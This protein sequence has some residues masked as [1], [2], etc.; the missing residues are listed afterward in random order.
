MLAAV[1]LAWPTGVCS[2]TSGRRA[3]VIL[4]D[5]FTWKDSRDLGG[6]ELAGLLSAASV[7][8]SNA[9]TAD[10]GQSLLAACATL[11]A[12]RRMSARESAGLGLGLYELSGGEAAVDIYLRRMGPL[13]SS[14]AATLP[15]A[16]AVCTAW[17]ELAV[18]NA[19]SAYRGKPGLLGE[20]LCRAGM[21]AAAIGTSDDR[22]QASR[23]A[24]LV[25]MDARGVVPWAQVGP[26]VNARDPHAPF[27]MACDIR[28]MAAAAAGAAATAAGARIGLVMI[29][30][31]DFARL[32]RYEVNLS[33]ESYNLLLAQCYGRLDSLL[34]EMRRA[35]GPPS[36]ELAYVLV[37]P[38]AASGLAPIAIAGWSYGVGL[39]TSPTTRREGLV[40]NLD[41]TPTILAGLGVGPAWD[42]D[43]APMVCAP[44]TAVSPGAGIG[45][46]LGAPTDYVLRA[47]ITEEAL[48]KS[49]E[50]R[51]PVLRVLIGLLVATVFGL[52]G[53][54][55][56]GRRASRWAV[57]LVRALL[58]AASAAPL[59]I[60]LGPV[61]GVCGTAASISLLV[62]GCG[63]LAFLALRA[64]GSSMWS[65]VLIS[66]ATAIVIA[67]DALTGGRL[68]ST[69][70]L[71]HSAVL[72]ARYYGVGNELM[73]LLVG[74]AALVG[75][76]L[77]RSAWP[78]AA[79]SGLAMVMLGHPSIGANFGGMISAAFTSLAIAVVAVA[80]PSPNCPSRR[81]YRL[82]LVVLAGLIVATLSAATALVLLDASN[83]GPSHIGRAW[84]AL[85]Q[86][87][88]G[89][90]QLAAIIMRKL[91]MNIRLLRYTAWTQVL[92]A[93]LII[94]GAMAASARGVFLQFRQDH[95]SLH[96]AFMGGLAGALAAMAVNDSGVVACA[97]LAMMPTLAM[98]GY[99]ADKLAA[100]DARQGA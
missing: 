49:A 19:E 67:A 51:G 55:I 66:G 79:A 47:M 69:S 86:R 8:C 78:S 76:G 72:G 85:T 84:R 9:R 46:G 44:V 92:I 27:G 87:T 16:A 23:P 56:L 38:T 58:V 48:A 99:A 5:G 68:A 13:T 94:L 26:G 34:A 52:L 39:L 29:D 33:R 1:F 71:G 17:P 22:A 4:V 65:A 10:P 75:A 3:V 96:A 28:A 70:L 40:A 98:L 15:S 89:Y 81:A 36:D 11:G 88:A 83:P 7:G 91:A 32:R 74:S 57:Q 14:T 43:G 100:H 37:S 21:G 97:T 25:A 2:G 20:S 95:F 24:V 45:A 64:S 6:P 31:G 54:M 80:R 30:M 41:F 82:R 63:I 60:L 35:M 73:G 90:R 12:G 62:G 53:V 50:A 93:F 18:V 77:S 59:L 61:V 42:C